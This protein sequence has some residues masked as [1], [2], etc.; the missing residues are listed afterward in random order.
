MSKKEPYISKIKIGPPKLTKYERARI[1]GARAL[2][3]TMGASPLIPVE[4]VGSVDP[5]DIAEKEL[6]M[7]I[8]PI[9]IRRRLPTGEYQD[10]PLKWL[11][12]AEKE[13]LGKKAVYT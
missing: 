9:T 7:G 1:I 6:E 5:L 3:L 2:Q 10:I 8:L 12:E 4:M 13:A 11:L